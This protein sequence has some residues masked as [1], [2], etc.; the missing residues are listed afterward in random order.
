ML[1]SDLG[2]RLGAVIGIVV[3]LGGCGTATSTPSASIPGA[4]TAATASGGPGAGDTGAN[5]VVLA[6]GAGG[7]LGL[8]ALD[9]E[10]RWVA[11]G[12]APGATALCATSEGIAV[13]FGHTLDLRPKSDLSHA[14]T[15]M[16][17]EWAGVAPAAPIVGLGSSPG[18]RLAIV[19][20]DEQSLEYALVGADG[21][22]TAL[23]PQPT[24]TFMPLVDWLDE[25][26]LLVLSTDN[27]QISRVAVLDTVAHSLTPSGAL[28]GVRLFAIS[29]DRQ[30]VALAMEDAIYALPASTLLGQ[31]SPRAVGHVAEF[32][33][34]WTLALN[35]DGSRLFAFSGAVAS[36]GTVGSFHGLEYAKG[37]S[38]WAQTLDVP[39]PFKRI[40]GQAYLI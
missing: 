36:D 22:V 6:E 5:L 1:K 31:A 24:Q 21:A 38:G 9:A 16:T 2:I 10:S 15:V 32:H 12:T 25:A 34:V 4:A 13:A 40:V 26:R 19:T 39:T 29:S 14:G 23:S 8:W 37:A 30:V 3:L 18:K 27:Q 11:L 17:L 33:V 35:T 20:A 7:S 28:T